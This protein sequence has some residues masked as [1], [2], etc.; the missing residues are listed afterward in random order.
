[1]GPSVRRRCHDGGAAQVAARRWFRETKSTNS[2]GGSRSVRRSAG[3]Q[4]EAP[5]GLDLSGRWPVRSGGR[6]GAWPR[7]AWRPGF[8]FV[9]AMCGPAGSLRSVMRHPRQPVGGSL[10]T[11]RRTSLVDGATQG[12]RYPE[13]ACGDTAAATGVPRG[14]LEMWNYCSAV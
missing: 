1:M 4:R 14:G 6:P 8:W 9:G 7:W 2:R 11:G 12:F 10:P 5:L 3:N 13:G